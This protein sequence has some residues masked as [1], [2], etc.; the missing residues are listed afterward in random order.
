MKK[1]FNI[2]GN[3]YVSK[4]Y[5]MDN[6]QKVAKV[7]ELVEE[8]AYFSINR[9]RQY[10]KTTTLFAIDE[11]LNKTEEYLS[12]RMNFQGI[13]Q[14]WH[15]SDGNFAQMFV[16]EM[17]KG[18]RY[19]SPEFAA[20]LKEQISNVVS[21]NDLSDIITELIHKSP[22]KIVILIDEVDAS[23]NYMPFLRFLAM[24]RTKYLDRES[25]SNL[26][27]HSVVLVGVHD[28][29][30]LK[31]KIR[32]PE[33]AQYNSPWNIAVDFESV[34]EF[35]PQEIAP[36]LVEY[37]Q[38][39]NVSMDIAA[40]A[41]KLYDYTSG[42]PFLISRLCLLI[43]DKILPKKTTKTWDL[44]DV[45]AAVKLILR[46]VNTNFESL[47]KNLQNHSDLYD[48]VYKML[49]DGE[50]FK[51]NPHNDTIHKGVIYG[52]FKQNGQLKI[53]NQIYELLIYNYLIST[54]ETNYQTN[55]YSDEHPFLL[56]DNT[57]NFEKVL[58]K[59]QEYMRDN[60]SR[61]DHDFLEKHWRLLFFAFMTPILNGRGFIFREAQTSEEK[62]MDAVITFDNQKYI[63]ELKI[64]RGEEAHET[65]LLQLHDYLE[66]QSLD[67][68]F[69]IIFDYRKSH[70][71]KN[72]WAK[73]KNK[74]IFATWV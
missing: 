56:P 29:K 17:Y 45:D 38:A 31:Y 61:K 8:G 41:Q 20:F 18:L 46:E 26:T 66:R 63:V 68:G 13:D 37:S 43:V 49:I 36:M 51:F 62:R 74:D 15:E 10:G 47:I 69:L 44:T 55:V 54:M 70:N 25:P 72:E 60:H 65:G 21:M 50:S 64:W 40:I 1:K 4:H 23:S 58:K 35:N 57:M 12:I 28:V 48:L 53:H 42:Y 30:S 22:K 5:M 24:L 67:K 14:K 9:P 33:E 27:F 19:L 34:M 11:K 59:F 52:V 32:N 6:S 16:Q 7:Y 3:C 71:W 2:T 39:E 73:V